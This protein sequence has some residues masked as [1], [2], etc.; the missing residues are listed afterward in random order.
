VKASGRG[1]VFNVDAAGAARARVTVL[2]MRG[3][4]LSNRVSPVNGG[5]LAWD[6][7]GAGGR[8]A[9][10]GIYAVRLSLMDSQG[11]VVRTL[12]AKIPLMR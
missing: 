1:L 4:V 12:D 6:G 2:D 7:R 10:S 3:L 5:V 9:P 11:G 8:N